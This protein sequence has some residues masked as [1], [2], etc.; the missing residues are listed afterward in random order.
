MA[1]A[2]HPS[3]I[4]PVFCWGRGLEFCQFWQFP[5]LDSCCWKIISY[6]LLEKPTV[7]LNDK[8]S[9][10]LLE[11]CFPCL[12]TTAPK[13]AQRLCL[14]SHHCQGW[15]GEMWFMRD[16]WSMEWRLVYWEHEHECFRSPLTNQSWSC[17]ASTTPVTCWV[18]E[19]QSDLLIHPIIRNGFS[20]KITTAFRLFLQDLQWFLVLLTGLPFG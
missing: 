2:L 16:L 7:V 14:C 11:L 5:V 15:P 17:M 13:G 19:I 12:G 9:W 1:T 18:Q 20:S 8:E 3:E 6:N 10:Y 4:E